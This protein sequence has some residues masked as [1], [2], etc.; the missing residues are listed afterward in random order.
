MTGKNKL[1]AIVLTALLMTAFMI[2]SVS[3]AGSAQLVDTDKTTR[4]DWV[5]NYGSEGYIVITDDDSL[6][7]IP[8]YAKLDYINENDEIPSFWTWYDSE[9]GFEDADEDEVA[10]RLPSAL[11]KNADKK[12]RIASCYYSGEFFTVT[13]DIGGETK[14]VSLYT[15]DYDSYDRIADVTV[16][17]DAEKEIIAP[18]EISDYHEGL[19]L[20]YKISGK[21]EFTFEN[22][23]GANAVISGIFFD[24]DPAAVVAAAETPAADTVQPE[25]PVVAAENSPAPAPAETQSVVPTAAAPTGDTIAIMFMLICVAAGVG[26]IVFLSIK[27]KN[28]RSN[29]I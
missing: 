28:K 8:S 24:P 5:G 7:S 14:I 19:Y 2:S 10:D 1:V 23:G 4:G 29:K 16:Y 21:V 26:L 27:N 3:A 15:T 22:T 18:M 12:F 11:F 9:E 20:K 17:D 25:A 13:I 6:Q